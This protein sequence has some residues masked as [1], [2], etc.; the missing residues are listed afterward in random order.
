M[1]ALTH[2]YIPVINGNEI[3][4]IRYV[5]VLAFTIA[6]VVGYFGC[7]KNQMMRI[8]FIERNNTL[9]KNLLYLNVLV[10]FFPRF[11]RI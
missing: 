10:V 6:H 4:R 1:N 2:T 9:K 3:E 11:T 8:K 5:F 7:G